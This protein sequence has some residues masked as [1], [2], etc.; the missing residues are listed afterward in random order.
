MTG[1]KTLLVQNVP[2]KAP[3]VM[4][5][6][7]VFLFVFLLADLVLYPFAGDQGL[8]AEWFRLLA[9]FIT[10]S[11]IYAVSFRRSTWIVALLFAGPVVWHRT[12]VSESTATKLG[13]AGLAI[14][15]AF[16]VFVVVVIFRRVFRTRDVGSQTIFGAVSIYLMV[17]FAFIRIYMFLVALQPGAFYLDP[18]LN[19]HTLP[20][21]SDLTYYSFGTMT[22]L[23]ATG[24][25]P[26]SGQARSLS[27]IEAVLGILYLGVLVSRLIAMYRPMETDGIPQKSEE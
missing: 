10:I 23:G 15:V 12:I 16:D 20:D 2:Q 1:E 22:S 17:G 11:S 24:I 19:R 27:V 25:S 26:V 13:L 18:V 3:S 21:H 7:F 9:L 6:K 4:A 8:R 5:G 14:G